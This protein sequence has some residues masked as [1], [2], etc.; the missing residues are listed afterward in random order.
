MKRHM[1]L[2]PLLLAALFFISTL[3]Y[4]A[5]PQFSLVLKTSS[6]NIREVEGLQYSLTL[7]DDAMRWDVSGNGADSPIRL[8]F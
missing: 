5:K 6:G 7:A 1:I 3:L 4:M 2:F 8:H